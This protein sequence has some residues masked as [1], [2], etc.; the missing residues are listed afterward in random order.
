MSHFVFVNE[1]GRA[2]QTRR[3][4]VNYYHLIDILSYL[5]IYLGSYI[6][7]N[8]SCEKDVFSIFGRT[9]S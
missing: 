1:S 8:G 3:V 4:F 2:L 6:S 7:S 5:S 9:A